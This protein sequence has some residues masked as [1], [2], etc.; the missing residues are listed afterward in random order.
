ML[1]VAFFA[2]LSLKKVFLSSLRYDFNK[3]VE[4][5][6]LRNFS[7]NT[8]HP[9]VRKGLSVVG[10]WIASGGCKLKSRADDVVLLLML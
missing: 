2:E 3:V 8:F 5:V 10:E 9:A 6:G 4:R 1:V 7:S